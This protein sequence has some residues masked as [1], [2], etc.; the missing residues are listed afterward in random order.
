MFARCLKHLN[1]ELNMID[2]IEEQL[3]RAHRQRENQKRIDRERATVRGLI[4]ALRAAG[5]N[6]W[7]VHDGGDCVQTRTESAMID[8]VFAVDVSTAVFKH[9]AA[10]KKCCVSFVCGEGDDIIADH[11]DPDSD[12]HAFVATINAYMT[13]RGLI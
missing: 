13:A 11:S 8:A 2:P 10:P 5:W 1:P 9:D 3:D 12:P 7:N 4:R 6:P